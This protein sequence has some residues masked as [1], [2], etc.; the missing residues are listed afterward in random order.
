MTRARLISLAVLSVVVAM[1]S[2]A[3][4]QAQSAKTTLTDPAQATFFNE[5]S[6]R[7]VCQ[8]GCQMILRVCNHQNC[9]SAIPMRQNIEEQI[10][11]GN[12]EEE[13]VQSFVEEHGLKIL[14]SPPA[15]GLNLAAWIMPGFAVL[16]GL[17]LIVHFAG[18]WAARRRLAEATPAVAIDAETRERVAREI[19]EMERQI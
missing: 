6:D 3:P 8:C 17:L 4:A 15:E 16:V 2:V 12:G 11:A 14:S 7:L 9:P 10:L 19:K 5:I 1:F 13:I 18:H